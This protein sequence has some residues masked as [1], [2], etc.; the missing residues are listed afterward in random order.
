L[1]EIALREEGHSYVATVVTLNVWLDL[2]FRDGRKRKW[3]SLVGGAGWCGGVDGQ[4][5]PWFWPVAQE[6]VHQVAAHSFAAVVG[7]HGPLHHGELLCRL[8]L[9][10]CWP[11]GAP[12]PLAGRHP[13]AVGEADRPAALDRGN[14]VEPRPPHLLTQPFGHLRALLVR[15][16]AEHRLVDG[17]QGRGLIDRLGR[18]EVP[19]LRHAGGLSLAASSAASLRRCSMHFI[20][21]RAVEPRPSSSGLHCAA[22]W[23]PQRPAA[24]GRRT[25]QSSRPS[26]TSTLP[27]SNGWGRSAE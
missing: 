5:R 21:E 23:L 10:R 9:L 13:V 20:V 4:G 14:E 15:R 12:P 6:L 11:V 8:H 7:Q 24:P 25:R 17:L 27:T 3:Q 22:G 1:S 16:L 2:R 26:A 18:R 19:V